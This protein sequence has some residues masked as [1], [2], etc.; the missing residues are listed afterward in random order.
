MT[1]IDYPKFNNVLYLHLKPV[2]LAGD[3]VSV[4]KYCSERGYTLIN[5]QLEN[6]RFSNDGELLYQ[7]FNTTTGLWVTESGFTQVVNQ[8]TIN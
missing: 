1:I 8:L 2:F 3:Q 7:W 5:F 6:Q 4:N